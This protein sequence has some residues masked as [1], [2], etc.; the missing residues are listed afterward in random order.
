MLLSPSANDC[1]PCQR[2][3]N[4]VIDTRKIYIISLSTK[5]CWSSDGTAV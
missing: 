2:A 5:D 3:I 4:D 1:Q